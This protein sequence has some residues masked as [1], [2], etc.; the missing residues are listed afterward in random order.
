MA[1]LK[2]TELPPV[3][4]VG[5]GDAL[6]VVVGGVTSKVSKANLFAGLGGGRATVAAAAPQ[7][8]SEGDQW[9]DTTGSPDAALKI[10]IGSTWVS[11]ADPRVASWARAVSPYRD[12]TCRAPRDGLSNRERLPSRGRHVGRAASRR[13]RR[14][15]NH[16][17]GRRQGRDL[18]AC[19][20]AVWDSA[21]CPARHGRVGHA[22]SSRGRDVANRHHALE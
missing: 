18:G 2:I 12:G 16:H 5:D 13:K 15:I 8:P 22:I 7:N 11:A 3:T 1:D 10:R 21:G 19:C 17:T 9:W 20:L 4:A 6:A 14:R